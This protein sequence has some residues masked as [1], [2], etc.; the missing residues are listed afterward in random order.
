[1]KKPTD[2]HANSP[3]LARW[4][5]GL[6]PILAA[7]GGTTAWTTAV[8]ILCQPKVAGRILHRV[9]SLVYD[10]TVVSVLDALDA[11]RERADPILRM[12]PG[13]YPALDAR[14]IALLVQF[15][16]DGSLSTM[17]RHQIETYRELG[18][19]VVLVSNSPAFPEPAWHAARQ[20]A[21]LVVH[22]RNE[23]LDFGAWKDLLPV[24]LARWPAAEEVLL[25]ND[26]V[27]GP[28]RPVA[29]IIN[30]VRAAGPGVFG[31]LESLQGGPHLQSWFTL[32]R[33]RPA[34]TDL[35]ACL[36]TFRLSRSKWKIVQRGELR[37][38]RTMRAAG[39]RVAAWYR[40]EDLLQ[41]A[42]ADPAEHAYLVRALPA[43]LDGADP[44][45]Q[46]AILAAWPLNPAHHLWRVLTGP[47]G[48][49]FIKTELV[50]RNPGR[51]PE[52]ETWPELVP[53]DSPCPV[54]MLRAHLA[55][56]GP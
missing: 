29:P 23:G 12:E 9:G 35:A 19:A 44:A 46:Q 15:S 16:P 53:A 42:L 1:M 4:R 36:A 7:L 50:R 54:P 18:F 39:H 5:H 28:I 30:A 43:L 33:G 49:P 52:V 48:C 41:A 32:V 8:Q 6:N 55:M 21:A 14:S 25:V 34:I 47:A 45:R 38:A 3:G 2:I 24:A 51:L 11:R 56:L 13:D 26:S 37:L 31:L 10:H 20:A 27:L 17:V 22:R 40:Y